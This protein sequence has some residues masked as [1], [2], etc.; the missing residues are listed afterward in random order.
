M[1]NYKP[2]HTDL[3]LAAMPRNDLRRSDAILAEI[4]HDYRQARATPDGVIID[5]QR[6]LGAL[7]RWATNTAL[8]LGE[9][10]DAQGFSLGWV[11]FNADRNGEWIRNLPGAT[12]WRDMDFGGI[13]AVRPELERI[14]QDASDIMVAIDRLALVIERNRAGEVQS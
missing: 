12:F 9:P 5:A 8:Y 2:T 4:K 7:H 13:E 11:L 14:R 1:S 10:R 6:C 3:E